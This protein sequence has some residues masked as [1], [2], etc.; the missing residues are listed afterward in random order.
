MIT[1]AMPGNC[2]YNMTSELRTL[3]YPLLSMSG[4]GGITIWGVLTF[5]I[6]PNLGLG[7]IV[8]EG[9]WVWYVAKIILIAAC[10]RP[11]AGALITPAPVLPSCV[12]GGT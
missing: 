10:L 6:W 5:G 9:I 8:F 1:I 4:L 11:L 7:M 12:G 2:S 3:N